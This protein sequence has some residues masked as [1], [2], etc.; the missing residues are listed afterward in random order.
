MFYYRNLTQSDCPVKSVLGISAK[1]LHIDIRI[2]SDKN[3]INKHNIES[4]FS[5]PSC[6]FDRFYVSFV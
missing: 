5:H 4:K 3:K 2:L 1:N 6:G